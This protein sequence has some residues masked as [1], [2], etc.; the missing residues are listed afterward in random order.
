MDGWKDGRKERR[1]E[2]RKR[3]SNG[4]ERKGEIRGWRK[5]GVQEWMDMT[6]LRRVSKGTTDRGNKCVEETDRQTDTNTYIQI[7]LLACIY[8][9]DTNTYMQIGFL[10][11]M[12]IQTGHTCVGHKCVG[13]TAA[14]D[15]SID[16]SSRPSL[17]VS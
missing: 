2:G 8:R 4:T 14:I 7:G 6:P 3:E 12:Y 17:D 5:T 15:R 10:A 1:V 16:R 9:T 11:C 13:Q